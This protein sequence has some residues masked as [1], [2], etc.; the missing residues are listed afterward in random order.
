M[1]YIIL[2]SGKEPWLHWKQS[3]EFKIESLVKFEHELK[4]VYDLVKK[5][6]DNIFE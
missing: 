1:T 5:V 3:L 2:K 6:M 4:C